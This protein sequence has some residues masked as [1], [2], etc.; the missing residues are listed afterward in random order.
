M[1]YTLT[2]DTQWRIYL[3]V[4]LAGFVVAT[5]FKTISLFQ[6]RSNESMVWLGT[7]RLQTPGFRTRR[8]LH[9]TICLPFRA[10]IVAA[11]C[12][13]PRLGVP[14][15]VQATSIIPAAQ[16]FT[17]LSLSMSNTQPYGQF[18]GVAWWAP[19]RIVHAA[20][21]L[22][23]AI[24]SVLSP[25]YAYIPLGLDVVFSIVMTAQHDARHVRCVA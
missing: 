1:W 10:L 9:W 3:C 13:L 16:A 14:V 17:W 5:A 2:E 25:V 11:V 4:L 18:K 20:T 22:A 23:F 24:T 19:Q 21:Y 8:L 12:L 7:L 15:V 6:T